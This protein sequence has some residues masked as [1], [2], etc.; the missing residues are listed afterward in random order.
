MGA[1]SCFFMVEE[2]FASGEPKKDGS[3][4][5]YGDLASEKPNPLASIGEAVALGG[6]NWRYGG[7][8]TDAVHIQM[9]TGRP[10]RV[11]EVRYQLVDYDDFLMKRR[12]AAETKYLHP[13]KKKRKKE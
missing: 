11:R 8:A 7:A 4:R 9:T 1:Q 3:K 10:T 6:A 13:K 5:F 2:L 12:H